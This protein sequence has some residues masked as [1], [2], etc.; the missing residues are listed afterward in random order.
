MPEGYSD[1]MKGPLIPVPSVM[2]ELTDRLRRVPPKRGPAAGDL[3]WM[4]L[5]NGDSDPFD[6]IIFLGFGPS[7]SDPIYAAK[8]P[9]MPQNGRLLRAEYDRLKELW[10]LI[11]SA[12]SLVLPEPIAFESLDGQPVLV[13]SYVHGPTML[14]AAGRGFWA[15]EARALGLV[16]NAARSLRMLH[17]QA[18]L[19]LDPGEE[20]ASGFEPIAEKFRALFSLNRAE[21]IAL[22]EVAAELGSRAS[23]ATHKVLIQG[24]FWHG[25]LI[26]SP[27]TGNLVFIDWQY[28][29]WSPDVSIDV[30]LFLLAA[31]FTAAPYGTAVERA[32]GAGQILAAWRSG[33]IST[34]L[35]E[36]GRPEN[37]S[38]LPEREGMLATC[39]EKAVRPALE[40]G[41]S[42]PDDLMWRYL[43]A[44]LV[45]RSEEDR[46]T[47]RGLELVR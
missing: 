39:V 28:A 10:D 6:S 21:E 33:I 7:G 4:I 13:L 24:D 23:T 18:C 9:R 36:Y 8:V 47:S 42:H 19:P 43:F 41:Y 20:A 26:R 27:S 38:L 12:A 45:D 44:E 16:Q 11:G 35:R 15:E 14:K 22:L 30:Y 32:K 34:Y 31:S 3:E 17:E 1:P 2:E 5:T 25:N 40:Y 46:A 29:R 37:Y